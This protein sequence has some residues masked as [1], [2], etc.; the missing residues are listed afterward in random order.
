M[1][2][3]AGI[4]T[5]EIYDE[6]GTLVSQN[7]KMLFRDDIGYIAKLEPNESYR[8]NGEEH[9]S[10]EYYQ[11]IIT[12]PGRYKVKAKAEFKVSYGQLKYKYLITSD[13]IYILVK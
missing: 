3:S 1:S 2:H 5:Y 9:R 12:N 8:Q 4:F 11:F 7:Q 10:K 13:E 6:E